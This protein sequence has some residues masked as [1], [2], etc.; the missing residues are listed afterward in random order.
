[1]GSNANPL[2]R[3]SARMTPTSSSAWISSIVAFDSSF[4]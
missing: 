4:R 3:R 2:L 1:M